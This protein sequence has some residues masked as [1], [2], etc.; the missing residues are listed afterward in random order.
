MKKVIIYAVFL[1]SFVIFPV[2]F[3]FAAGVKQSTGLLPSNPFYFIKEWARSVKRTWI[4][5]TIKRI[6]YDLDIVNEKAAEL[7][8]L[9]QIAPDK[10]DLI[11]NALDNYQLS[12]EQL[13]PQVENL[14]G[15]NISDINKLLDRLVEKSLIHAELLSSLSSQFNKNNALGIELKDAEK[16]V[17][18]MMAIIPQKVEKS[19]DFRIRLQ[20]IIN[21]QDQEFKELKAAEILD[22]LE[23]IL[24]AGQVRN[25]INK[26][27][28]DLLLKFGMQVQNGLNQEAFSKLVMDPMTQLKLLDEIRKT[29]NDQD[30]KNKL[31]LLRQRA[32]DQV[33]QNRK[34]GEAEAKAALDEAAQF[35]S[36]LQ[37]K[38]KSSQALDQAKFYLTQAQNFYNQTNYVS[39]FSQAVSSMGVSDEV[40]RQ[41]ANVVA[42]SEQKKR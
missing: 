27:K 31:N 26:L 9:S 1:L 32:L 35:L 7:Q 33:A 25:E 22:Y 3:A 37:S 10:E 20:Q 30:L 39:A 6:E 17:L 21:N 8:K 15:L 41:L 38:V 11:S 28:K 16:R 40:L 2:T 34:I 14:K 4:F 42:L 18:F 24:P 13:I 23:A 36:V 19:E 12:L 5:D 29:V